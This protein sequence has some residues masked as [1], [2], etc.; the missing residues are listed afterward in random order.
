VTSGGPAHLSA[1]STL[2]LP[3]ISSV[4]T[5]LDADEAD[6]QLGPGGAQALDKAGYESDGGEELEVT[7]PE[8]GKTKAWYWRF[9]KSPM[10][11]LPC[12][13]LVLES[14]TDL[15]RLRRVPSDATRL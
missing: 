9:N 10:G 5:A 12:V 3:G 1:L 4:L 11:G 6:L 13:F 2:P 7:K 14:P 15:F 8:D